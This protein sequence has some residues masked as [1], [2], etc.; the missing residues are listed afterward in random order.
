MAASK[1]PG[2][3]VR[4]QSNGAG[5][6]AAAARAEAKKP[7]L[8]SPHRATFARWFSVS[9][10]LGGVVLVI[11]LIAS[12]AEG[13]GGNASVGDSIPTVDTSAP[14]VKTPPVATSTTPQAAKGTVRCDPIVGSGSLNAGK[15]YPVISSASS[16]HPTNCGDA[17][18]V[19]LSAL[20]TG[21]TTVSGW[22]CRMDTGGDPIAVCRSG[23]RTIAARG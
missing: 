14:R 4:A 10:L 11:V 12:G 8:R 19:L 5:K 9:A 17:H 13:T 1:K 16:G 6:T 21:S 22:G 3:D 15:S 18:S 23:G 7:S 20:S 2:K